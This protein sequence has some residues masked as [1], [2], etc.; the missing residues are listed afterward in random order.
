MMSNQLATESSLYLQQHAENPVA[1]YP[2][3]D[4]AFETAR[5]EGKPLLVSIGYSSCHWCH[6]MAHEC[7]EDEAAAAVLNELYVSVKVD[8][9]EYPDVDGF[10]MEYLT[11][12]TGS[13]GW[14][15]NVLV[16]PNGVPF[17]G[18]TYLPKDRFVAVLERVHE[19][20]RKQTDLADKQLSARFELPA[21]SESDLRNALADFRLPDPEPADGPQFPQSAYLLLAHAVGN[22]TVVAEA[23]DDLITKGLYDHVEGGWFRYTVDP[24]WKIPHFEKMLYDQAALLLL[25][26]ETHGLR[27]ELTTYGIRKTVDWLEGHMR[28]P[29]GLYGSA[30]DADTEEG[31]GVYYTI[32]PTDDDD[33]CRLFCLDAAGSH[34][35]RKHPWVDLSW[36]AAHPRAAEA[37]RARYVQERRSRPAPGLDTKA[38][39]S[40]NALLGYA[41]VR[42]GDVLAD[43][44]IRRMGES[45]HEALRGYVRPERVYHVV[46]GT[47]GFDGHEHLEDVAAFLL[48]A[49]AVGEDRFEPLLRS[50]EEK[51]MHDSGLYHTSHRVYENLS[52]WQ[53]LPAPSGGSMLLLALSTKDPETARKTA[54]RVAGL[55]GVAVDHPRFFAGW[56]RSLCGIYRCAASSASG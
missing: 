26:A 32:P 5:S 31:E 4:A 3:G 2:W 40:W 54:A 42:A 38:V 21:A 6:V 34:D 49:S 18:F 1:W 30:T 48:L 52:L 19:E 50:V 14:P 44:T 41:L 55:G 45:L 17:Y 28:L 13:G 43:P 11:R 23:L 25:S 15:L 35:G 27:P 24:D 56:I 39:V 7:Y 46:Y 33:A 9:E 29:S 37:V 53:D 51:F 36:Q 8:R 20:Y 12:V 47:E 16:N 22:R 10:Y